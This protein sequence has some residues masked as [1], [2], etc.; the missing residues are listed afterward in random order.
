MGPAKSGL[1]ENI[2]Y[3]GQVISL[4]IVLELLCTRVLWKHTVRAV[5]SSICRSTCLDRPSLFF[6]FGLLAKF[7]YF[8]FLVHVHGARPRREKG[9]A[10]VHQL[11]IK[12]IITVMLWYHFFLFRRAALRFLI[13]IYDPYEIRQFGY[14]RTGATMTER[15]S[16]A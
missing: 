4:H 1:W 9:H 14:A 8:V 2:Q 5:H 15:S 11:Y 10:S 3:R 16:V 7:S 6:W 13:I 12:S